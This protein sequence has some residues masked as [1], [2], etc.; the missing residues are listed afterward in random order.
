[1]FFIFGTFTCT[2]G[3]AAS[4]TSTSKDWDWKWGLY[5]SVGDDVAPDGYNYVVA[6][7]NIHNT[8]DKK[9]STNPFYWYLT[10]DSITYSPDT[11]TWDSSIH[12]PSVKGGKGGKASLTCVY[13]V[14]GAPSF[15]TLS[16]DD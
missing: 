3:T 12:R 16:Y 6:V 5:H 1:M 11:P 7:I 15:A 8:G 2:L 9:I 13:L 14:Q 4:S 10:A